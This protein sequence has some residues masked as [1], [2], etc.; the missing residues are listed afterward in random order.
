MVEFWLDGGGLEIHGFCH[1][2][3]HI[4]GAHGDL[5]SGGLEG[6]D[7][8]VGGACWFAS[9]ACGDDCSCVSHSF[10]FWCGASGDEGGD[11]FFDVLGDVFSGGFFVFASDFTD[12]EDGVGVGV[13]FEHADAVDVVDS[14]DGV[15]TD[16]DAGGLGE[17]DLGGLP[18]GFVG[19]CSGA[20]DDTY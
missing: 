11:W 19:E 15:T 9:C 1:G 8:G 17:T 4:C 10:A 2:D 12:H 7:L 16:P 6:G 5:D 20:G 13:F 18:D 3:S 14:T